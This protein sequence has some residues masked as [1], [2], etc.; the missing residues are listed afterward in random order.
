METLVGRLKKKLELE[1][2]ACLLGLISLE[3]AWNPTNGAGRLYTDSIR[4]EFVKACKF[5]IDQIQKQI[6]EEINQKSPY[7]NVDVCGGLKV[8]TQP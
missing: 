7:Q 3:K 2:M 1:K 4:P 6:E 5:R 8:E